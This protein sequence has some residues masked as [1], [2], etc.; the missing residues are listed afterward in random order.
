MTQSLGAIGFGPLKAYAM[1]IFV[2]FYTPLC[3][4]AVIAQELKS[5]KWTT[6]I[7]V[8]QL[9]SAWLAS[10]LVYQIGSLFI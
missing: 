4:C 2:L 10:T 8:F 7:V 1:M 3:C 6:F 9:V 5:A